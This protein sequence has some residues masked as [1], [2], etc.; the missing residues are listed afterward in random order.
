M[1]PGQRVGV[2]QLIEDAKRALPPDEMKAYE[3]FKRVRAGDPEAYLEVAG[4]QRTP[5]QPETPKDPNVAALEAKIGTLEETLKY[6]APTVQQI[7]LIKEGN[8]IASSVTK[9]SE[10]LPYL[11]Y[12]AAKIP[13][14]LEKV[15]G[16]YRSMLDQARAMNKEIDHNQAAK[17]EILAYVLTKH[18]NEQA[19]I[20]N[21]YGFKVPTTAPQGTTAQAVGANGQPIP[22][23]IPSPGAPGTSL[24]PTTFQPE[25]KFDTNNLLERMRASSAARQGV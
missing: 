25:G 20:A 7:E 14:T 12:A 8:A 6:V 9:H 3:L 22:A 23:R 1:A 16:E 4:I 17:N 5:A 18:E 19:A 15:H 11:A 24:S 10:K 21:G 13:G 2:T